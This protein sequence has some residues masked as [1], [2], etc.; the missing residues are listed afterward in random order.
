MKVA[1]SRVDGLDGFLGQRTRAF[2]RTRSQLTAFFYGREFER[3]R[4]HRA[5]QMKQALRR[6]GITFYPEEWPAADTRI[7]LWRD[8]SFVKSND[9]DQKLGSLLPQWLEPF[10][11][12]S[13]SRDPLGLQAPAER[14]VNEVLPGLT[15]FTSRAGYYGFLTW[16]I[17]SVNR[18]ASDAIPRRSPRHEVLNAFERALALCEFVHHGLEDDSCS[19]IGQRSKLRVLSGNEGE[20]YR[21]PE[22]ILK[23]QDSAGSFRLFATSLVSLGLA[24][25]SDELAADGLLPFQLTSLGDELATAFQGH[26]DSFFIPFAMGE[27]KQTRET[28]RQ[29]GKAL[30]FS[31]IAR[32]AGYRKRFLRG[33]LLGNGRDAEKRYRTVE[34]LFAHGLLRTDK[35]AVESPDNLNEEDATILE[36]DAHGVG[37][38]NLDVVLHFYSC[39]PHDDLRQIQALAVFEV[40]SLGLTAIFRAAVVSITQSGKSDIAGLTHS[41]ASPAALATLWKMPMKDAKPKTVRKLVTD[42]LACDDASEA[43]SIGGALLVRVCRDPLLPAVWDLLIQI[44]REPIE[45][46]DRHIYQRMDRSLATTLPEML[47]AMV[48]RHELVSKRK[49]RQR[50][51]FVEGNNLIRD[52]PYAMGLGLHALRFPQLGSL[53][54]DIDLREE[55]LLD[56]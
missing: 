41:I 53:A 21:V 11:L 18:L 25:N 54:R 6:A 16:A 30:C 33:L 50:W 28:L 40:L 10:V 19:L 31:S 39:K 8:G 45:L 2:S 32:R 27:R 4:D 56:V 1:R 20:R 29:W 23:N 51:L 22:S 49:N 44:A 46:V 43:A 52:D 15:V 12:P 47:L 3:L 9:S 42:L 14:L 5:N 35:S 37:I 55:D 24:E 17:R 48:E 26:V 34:L 38:S 7:R 36:D 13:G